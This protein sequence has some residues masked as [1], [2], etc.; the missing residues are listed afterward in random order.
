MLNIPDR[1]L[2]DNLQY[3][4]YLP[5]SMYDLDEQC[6]LI[7]GNGSNYHDCPENYVV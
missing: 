6:R 3:M 2:Y 5:G 4:K 1:T 7:Y